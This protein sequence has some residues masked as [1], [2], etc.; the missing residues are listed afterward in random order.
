MTKTPIDAYA[1]EAAFERDHSDFIT[2]FRR[3]FQDISRH[4]RVEVPTTEIAYV[5]DYITSKS[6]TR[7]RSSNQAAALVDE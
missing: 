6:A 5:F 3:S 7:E 2:A 1:D 4:Y